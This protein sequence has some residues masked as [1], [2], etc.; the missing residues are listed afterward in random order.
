MDAVVQDYLG[1]G[2][3]ADK[4]V[5]GVPFYG[6]N[7]VG[8]SY[9]NNGL[10]QADS[11]PAQGTWASFINLRAGLYVHGNGN[12]NLG[13]EGDLYADGT[14]SGVAGGSLTLAYIYLGNTP[15]SNATYTLSGSGKIT[16]AFEEIAN[17][18]SSG[19]FTQSSGTNSTTWL[20]VGAM[21]SGT[22]N[23]SGGS[24]SVSN[25]QVGFNWG[26][27]STFNQSGGTNTISTALKMGDFGG[28]TGIFNLTGGTLILHEIDM[29]QPGASFNFGGGTLQANAAFTTSVP[30]T[31]TGNSG[32]ATVNTANYAVTLSGVLTG[33]GGLNKIGANALTLSAANDYTG[34]TT[35]TAGTLTLSSTGSLASN[36]I[37][38]G[39]GATFNVSALTGG[40]NVAA[41]RTLKGSGI[42]VG[43]L[44][45]NGIHAPGSS[46]GVE[47]VRGNYGM[48]GQLLIELAGT[49]A[50]SGYDQVLL[51]GG[52]GNYNA[53]LGGMLSLDW[54][55]FSGSSNVTKLCILKNDTAGT[56]SGVFA[57]YANGASL[58]A[59]DGRQW[60]IWYGAD[61]ATGNLSGGNDVFVAA[62]VPE[63]T[64]LAMLG[65]ATMILLGGAW[66]WPRRIV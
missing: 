3:P 51:S 8:V 47:T 60:Q 27:T 26:G 58:G 29:F 35:I 25:E 10:Y 19:T 39:S 24:L 41:G 63:P 48:M 40:F 46:P 16:A 15:N 23:L 1:A 52:S 62:S 28:S 14:A 55:G 32:N 43:N 30:M 6:Y 4:L 12:V 66:R 37:S 57:N 36:V 34:P 54:T 17:Y 64:T 31:L 42:I 38:V 65:I 53:T 9:N 44:T 11:G 59:H 5:M 50:G 49:T 56:L 33:P 7:W 22:Y 21:G 13:Y 61:A 18:Q 2:L 45:I 20:D